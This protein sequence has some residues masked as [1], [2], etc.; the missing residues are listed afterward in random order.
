MVKADESNAETID[1][2]AELVKTLQ[3]IQK[4]AAGGET[5]EALASVV[6]TMQAMQEKAAQAQQD[7]LVR[8]MPENTQAP[9]ISAYSHPEGDLKRPKT[10][11]KC[12]M[13][14]VGFPLTADNL[15]P[16]EIAAVNDLR[17]GDYFVTKGNGDRIPFQVTAKTKINGALESLSVWFPCKGDQLHDHRSMTAYCREAM[18][19]PVAVTA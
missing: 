14:W 9:G 1:V 15:T 16:T 19:A 18:G 10:P 13:F 11:L 3:A 8:T 5:A 2:Q 6:K 17:P 7:L 4:Q 12:E